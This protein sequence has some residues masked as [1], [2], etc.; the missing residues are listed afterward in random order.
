ML[1]PLLLLAS[2]LPAQQDAAAC[3]AVLRP[4][5]CRGLDA[6]GVPILPPPACSHAELQTYCS[7]PPA[8]REVRLRP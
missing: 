7:R 4:V 2:S 5:H 6:R 3:H 8:K 1:L